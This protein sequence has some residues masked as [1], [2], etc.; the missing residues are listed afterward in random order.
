M[1]KIMLILLALALLTLAACS[2][3]SDQESAKEETKMSEMKTDEKVVITL[4]SGAVGN[5]LEIAKKAAAMYNE[6]NPNVEIQIW[7]TPDS[8]SDRL[9]LYLQFL[10]AKS[11]KVDIYQID[12]VWPGD[13]AEH[14]IDLNNYGCKRIDSSVIKHILKNGTWITEKDVHD[15]YSTTGCTIKGSVAINN[16]EIKFVYDYGGIIYFD[17]RKI[18]GCGENCCRED[19]PNCSYDKSNLKGF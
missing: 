5:E 11:A 16:K 10:E 12:V 9:G 19:Y 18:L 1:K 15:Y 7:D 13:M 4:A 6:K 2:G 17:D 3:S 14:L 8:A